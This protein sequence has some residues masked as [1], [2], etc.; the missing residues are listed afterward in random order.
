MTHSP[1]TK[2]FL[3]R[4]G[5]KPA[6][7]FQEGVSLV[8]VVIALSILAVLS[9]VIV[10]AVVEAI[11][12]FQLNSCAEQLAS[13]LRYARSLAMARGVDEEVEFAYSPG[14][15]HRYGVRRSGFGNDWEPD[16]LSEADGVLIV[17]LRSASGEPGRAEFRGIL[18]NTITL[19]GS[20]FPTVLTFDRNGAAAL[21]G[22]GII[23][24]QN[25]SGGMRSIY[26]APTNG[27]V[28]VGD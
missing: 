18:F 23:T 17:I 6:F 22:T 24:L 13:H 1:K 4:P 20:L 25:Q 14:G 2:L 12:K 28:L 11:R 27:S 15:E 26:V 8:E 10:P 5:L 21:T 9:A 16:P 3:K 7:F 19:P